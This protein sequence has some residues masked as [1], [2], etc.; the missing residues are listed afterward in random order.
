MQYTEKRK[1]CTKIK[2]SMGNQQDHVNNGKEGELA[3]LNRVASGGLIEQMTLSKDVKK[4]RRLEIWIYR[5]RTFHAL[6][7]T[8]TRNLMHKCD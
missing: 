8:R 2:Q 7:T 1:I 6:E 5:G 4:V 3:I